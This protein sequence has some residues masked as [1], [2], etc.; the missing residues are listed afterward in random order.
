MDKYAWNHK[1]DAAR[2]H[3][4]E[5][6]TRTYVVGQRAAYPCSG[7]RWQYVIYFDPASAARV[8]SFRNASERALP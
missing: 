7:G 6:N 3:A 1:M 4:R 8:R 5:Q 2:R